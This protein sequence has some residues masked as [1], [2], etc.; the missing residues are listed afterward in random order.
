MDV[1][2]AV[3]KTNLI[4]KKGQALTVTL[5]L[6]A[7]SCGQAL[8]VTLALVAPWCSA[9]RIHSRRGYRHK[10]AQPHGAHAPARV[11]GEG[12]R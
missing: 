3:L 7:P 10:S 1:Q 12:E 5:A 2:Q 6:V 11:R 8:T 4:V 9:H